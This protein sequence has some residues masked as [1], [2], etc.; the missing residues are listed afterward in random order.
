MAMACE[1]AWSQSDAAAMSAAPVP[2]PAASQPGNAPPKLSVEV[3]EAATNNT[4]IDDNGMRQADFITSLTPS[5]DV[6]HKGAGFEGDLHASATFLDYAKGTQPDGVLPDLRATL[7]ATLLERWLRL[8]AA[9]YLQAAEADPFGVRTDDV[10]GSNRRNMW[11]VMAGPTLQHDL[12]PETSVVVRHQFGRKEGASGG[13]NTDATGQTRLDSNLTL[14]RL[15][16]KPTPLGV[17]AEIT[18]LDNRSNSDLGDSHFTLTTGRL[19][20]MLDVDTGFSLGAL[21][22]Q[23]RSDYL[24]SNH[25][26]PVYGGS[27][28]WTP[29]PRTHLEM[30]YEHHYF[31]KAGRFHLDHRT[32]FLTI[33][34]DIKRQPL[35]ATSS[36]GSVA[37]GGDVRS[38]L[39]AIL[40]TRYPDPATR[41][42]VV[43]GIVSSRGLNTSG[44]GAIDLIGDYPQLQTSAQASI[45]ML[46]SRDTLSLIAYSTT[47]RA[48]IRA[49]DPL[50]G[51]ST[52]TADNRQVG[53]AFQFAHRLGAQLSAAVQGTLS[54]IQ[55]LGATRDRSKEQVWRLSLLN[56]VSPRSD[57]TLALQWDRFETTA[58]GQRSFDATLGLVGLSHRF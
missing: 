52:A 42:A 51:L 25:V 17:A 20:A 27:L 56:H 49:G 44:T 22:G 5:L 12:S 36:F 8:D 34:I 2:V 26:D 45:A 37:Q 29:G 35:D 6:A 1:S 58:A 50:A 47:T 41:A 57:V 4:G 30:A 43:D 18:R 16:R 24:L 14:V 32:P 10:N 21:V 9:G 33:G 54:S 13:N 55:A 7:A 46:G 3:R 48:L 15:E 11:G 23:D 39:N 38:A 31:G 53:G 40:T 19:R 28:D